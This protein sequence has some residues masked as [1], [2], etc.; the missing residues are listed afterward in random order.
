MFGKKSPAEEL[1]QPPN[2]EEI[3]DDLKR[4]EPDDVV[5][6]TDIAS[7]SSAD[8]LEHIPRD[9]KLSKRFQVILFSIFNNKI[10][11]F[12]FLETFLRGRKLS[13]YCID[14]FEI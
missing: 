8:H 4:A 1:P 12:Q 9:F 10:C 11:H 6:T 3:L 13:Y 2:A 5:F 7:L 14:P